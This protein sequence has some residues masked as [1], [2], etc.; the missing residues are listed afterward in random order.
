M[1][2]FLLLIAPSFAQDCDSR[3][4]SKKITEASPVGVSTVFSELAACD[5]KMAA[6]SAPEAFGRM[7]WTNRSV[8]ALVAAIGMGKTELVRD[9]IGQLRSD[10]RSSAVAAL[11]AACAGNESVAEF[12]VESH[13]VLGEQFWNQRWYRSLSEC[14]FESVQALLAQAVD[15]AAGDRDRF[16]GVLEVF[17]RNQGPGAV[18]KITELLRANED[19]ELAVYLVKTY[20]DAAQ[21]GSAEGQNEEATQAAVAA[22]LELAP[23][24]SMRTLKQAQTTLLGMGAA[25]ES[26]GLPGTHFAALKWGDGFLHYG[27]L[28]V[29]TARCKGGK[30][31]KMGIHSGALTEVGKRFPLEVK[32]ASLAATQSVWAFDL[33]AKCKVEQELEVSVSEVPFATADALAAWHQVQRDALG[34]RVV[35]E[36]V[37][38]KT[39]EFTEDVPVHLD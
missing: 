10:E 5:A 28:A 27:L 35:K 6:R 24:F 17:A 11:G 31:T 18:G 21:V 26:E 15:E 2:P 37:V 19:K 34:E 20:A 33:S 12:L 22:I 29:E 8:G 25:L 14:R 23:Q 16:L 36:R 39:L 4:L 32:A 3:A 38:K 7:L 30:K 13:T 1:L 9:W